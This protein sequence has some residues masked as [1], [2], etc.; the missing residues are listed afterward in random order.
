MVTL[1]LSSVGSALGAVVASVAAFIAGIASAFAFGVDVSSV[2]T[3]I[4]SRPVVAASTSVAND[5]GD[6]S[7][8]S[9]RRRARTTPK[10]PVASSSTAHVGRL[11]VK[12]RVG[13][14]MCR[15]GG[16]RGR[17]RPMTRFIPVPLSLARASTGRPRERG[18]DASRRVRRVHRAR[19]VETTD[20]RARGD[21]SRWAR[22]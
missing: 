20:S 11:D 18:V 17:D 2:S 15:D 13:V 5:V 6:V 21:V 16:A 12:S 1:N 14:A 10:A 3:R 22:G 19:G 8:A 9:R 7:R 4:A